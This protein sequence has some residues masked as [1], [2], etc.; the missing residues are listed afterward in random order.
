MEEFLKAAIE[1]AKIS[2]EEGGFP[3]GSVLVHDGKI[4][5]R[6]HDRSI[7]EN[8]PL[9]HAVIDCLLNIGPVKKYSGSTL[10]STHMPCYLCSGGIVQFGIENLIIGEARN[11]E[12]DPAFL[13]DHWISVDDWDMDECIE[14]LAGFKGKNPGLWNERFGKH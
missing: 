8:N 12:G 14:L 7:Q 9:L 5:G 6:G 1:E 2:L 4:V 3:I 10:F 13:K 11:F